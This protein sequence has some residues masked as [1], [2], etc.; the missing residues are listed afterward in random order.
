MRHL[1]KR[2][3]FTLLKRLKKRVKFLLET[4]GRQDI[5]NIS[6]EDFTVELALVYC[7]PERVIE[8]IKKG[9]YEYQ[10]SH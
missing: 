5:Q 2:D 8:R 9:L 4:G 3:N 1:T 7:D 6:V 10:E